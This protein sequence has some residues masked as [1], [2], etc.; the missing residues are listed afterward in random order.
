MNEELIEGPHYTAT[1]IIEMERK[2]GEEIQNKMCELIYP[3]IKRALERIEKEN[4]K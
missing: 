3:I 4:L 2:L 1:E